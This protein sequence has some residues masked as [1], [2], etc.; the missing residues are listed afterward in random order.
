MAIRAAATATAVAEIGVHRGELQGLYGMD[1]KSE[2]QEISRATI[3]KA[4]L[5][6][7]SKHHSYCNL[8]PDPDLSVAVPLTH[9]GNPAN[10]LG[11]VFKIVPIRG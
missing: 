5:S 6:Q 3:A 7:H 2:S 8:L 9:F 11:K 4:K 1:M 10:L